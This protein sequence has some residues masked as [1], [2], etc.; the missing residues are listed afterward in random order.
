MLS[1]SSI[2]DASIDVNSGRAVAAACVLMAIG[3]LEF[4]I[5]PLF[6]GA[7]VEYLFFSTQ[8][9]GFIGS[10]YMVGFTLTSFTAVFWSRRINW[11]SAILIAAVLSSVCYGIIMS[12][13]DLLMILVLMFA[14]GCSRGVFYSISICSLGDT[15]MMERSFGLGNVAILVLAGLGMFVLPYIIQKWELFGLFIPLVAASLVSVAL[16]PWLPPCGMKKG[17][18]AERVQSGK[19]FLVFL[20]L[21]GLLIF[22]MGVCSIWA[23]LERIGNAG[24]LSPQAIGKILAISYVVVIAAAFLAAWLGD[25]IGHAVPVFIGVSTMLVGIVYMGHLITFVLFLSASIM[26]QAGWSFSYPFMM[27]VINKADISG[28]FVPLIA[29]AQGLGA[30]LGAGLGGSLLATS[31]GYNGIFRLGFISILV[32]LT[33]FGWV[34]FKQ[35]ERLSPK[36]VEMV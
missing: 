5:M 18:P 22:W 1:N 25:R 2:A 27:A 28:R 19:T 34:I 31:E 7:V 24:G 11:R 10:A 21:G 33:L 35:K 4:S 20:A 23:F 36:S 26:F 13:G 3:A 30:S 32:C 14:I 16:V 6:L 29:A 17:T 8:Q 12:T 15:E 9:I